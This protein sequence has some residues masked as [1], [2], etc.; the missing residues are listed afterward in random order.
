MGHRLKVAYLSAIL[1]PTWVPV[2]MEALPARWPKWG[3]TMV[4]EGMRTRIEVVF[5]TCYFLKD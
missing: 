5:D 4:S 2:V 1:S 3:E